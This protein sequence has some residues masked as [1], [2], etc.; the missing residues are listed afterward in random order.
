MAAVIKPNMSCITRYLFCWLNNVKNR[1]TTHTCEI[2]CKLTHSIN[3]ERCIWTEVDQLSNRFEIMIKH[4]CDSLAPTANC[5]RG[6]RRL[7]I[8]QKQFPFPLILNLTS[9][10]A[11]RN[12][13]NLNVIKTA[14]S[15]CCHVITFWTLPLHSIRSTIRILSNTDA[16]VIRHI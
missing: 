6:M 16:V 11:Y 12:P 3:T 10:S 9:S 5:P 2:I 7:T 15:R 4:L 8:S 1:R 13:N 14:E